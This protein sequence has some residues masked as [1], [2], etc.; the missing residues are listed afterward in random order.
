[1]KSELIKIHEFIEYQKTMIHYLLT[2]AKIK[3]S[4]D[5][6]PTV[7]EIQ[8]YLRRKDYKEIMAVKGGTRRKK[9]VKRTKRR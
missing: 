3:M 8:S 6:E 5:I 9:R 7:D 2:M 4:I 1:L